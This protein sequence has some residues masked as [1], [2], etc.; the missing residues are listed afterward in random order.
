MKILK[1]CLLLLLPAI[2]VVGCKKSDHRPG[3]CSDHSSKQTNNE[4]V[5]AKLIISSDEVIDISTPVV[6]SG[7]DD[8]DGG[9]KKQKKVR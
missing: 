9:D 5:N 3:S 2:G 7:D 4:T 6:G 8:R 1:I